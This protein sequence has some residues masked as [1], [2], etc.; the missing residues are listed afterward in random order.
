MDAY[1]LFPKLLP[2]IIDLS[3]GGENM[4]LLPK[5]IDDAAGP[6]AQAVGNT[7]SNLWD[8]GIG[9]HVQLWIKK[10]EVRQ[11]QNYQD[12]INRV[13]VKTQEIPEVFI[14]EPSL[15]I[16][17]PAI[18]ASKYY[19]ESEGLREMFANLI[20]SSIDVRK[21][22]KT[23][24][25]FVEIIKQLSPKDAGILMNFKFHKELPISQIR[26]VSNDNTFHT[27]HTHI[28]N[29]GGGD[30]YKLNVKS[31]SNLHRLGLIE[32]DYRVRS[33]NDY[34]Y[35]FVKTHPAFQEAQELLVQYTETSSSE[36]F[37]QIEASQFEKV[38]FVKGLCTVTPLCESFIDV[39]L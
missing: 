27:T 8:S 36:Q 9:S 30:T 22:E 2:P 14:Q 31:L 20:A 29:F 35:E 3:K 34:V 17:G 25:S 37:P 7:L 24:P 39:C 12:Y 11:Q 4:G 10:Q 33:T 38:T 5:F 15:H 32:I 19:I 26:L 28:M 18:E 16:V 21:A 13:E 23:H 6:P 1:I